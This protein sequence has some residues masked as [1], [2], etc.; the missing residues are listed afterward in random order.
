MVMLQCP[1][2]AGSIPYTLACQ[3]DACRPMG[4]TSYTPSSRKPRLDL[5]T[6]T[7]THRLFY[8][9]ACPHSFL[10]CAPQVPLDKILCSTHESYAALRAMVHR[11]R[12]HA[13]AR[14][15]ALCSRGVEG[16]GE[17]DLALLA[18]TGEVQGR[19]RRSGLRD[20]SCS[21]AC[22]PC[23]ECLSKSVAGP[24]DAYLVTPLTGN[25]YTYMHAA[26]MAR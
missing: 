4:V 16:L 23:P 7:H 3:H 15:E 12:A 9:C 19:G 20:T 6:H 14:M 17:D 25:M 2:H 22:L 11:E 1:S 13:A 10:H 5:T 24:R 18:N 26:S 8:H 21:H